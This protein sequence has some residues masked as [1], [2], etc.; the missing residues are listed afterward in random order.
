MKVQSDIQQ[1]ILNSTRQAA[2]ENSAKGLH[3]TEFL[4]INTPKNIHELRVITKRL[5]AFWQVVHPL[6]D[7]EAHFLSHNNL[8]RDTAK[9]LFQ[10]RE[11]D[12]NQ[13]LIMS[14]RSSV[15][16]EEDCIVLDALLKLFTAPTVPTKFQHK[17][18]LVT[19]FTAEHN[20]WQQLDASKPEMQK[21]QVAGLEATFKKARGLSKRAIEKGLEPV[22]THQWRKWAKYWYYQLEALPGK[23][24]NKKSKDYIRALEHLTDALGKYHDLHI[25]E[26]LIS[27]YESRKLLNVDTSI[28]FTLIQKE[29]KRLAK[30][31]LKFHAQTFC[32]KN[33]FKI[34]EHE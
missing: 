32:D 10:Y 13:K 29:N 22:V 19:C 25:L 30:K 33:I 17:D 21:R 5:R 9:S 20:F 6:L 16:V 14:F 15:D 24:D 8:L 28:I 34:H 12:V 4:D 7:D 26:N 27:D 23:N 2:L 11:S 31:I 3:I 1:N 18:E